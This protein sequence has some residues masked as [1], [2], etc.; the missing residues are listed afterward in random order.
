M[1]LAPGQL[2]HLA[3]CTSHPAAVV[4]V[5]GEEVVCEPDRASRAPSQARLHYHL[6][7]VTGLN[8]VIESLA[9]RAISAT[10]LVSVI[11]GSRWGRSLLSV[12]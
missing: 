8:S 10:K 1:K 12:V 4:V 3:S 7:A 11:M 2:R 9:R 5:V 6:T